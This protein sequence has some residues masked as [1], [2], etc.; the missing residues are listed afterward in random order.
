MSSNLLKIHKDSKDES[1]EN[2]DL[3]EIPASTIS[4]KW[5]NT[6]KTADDYTSENDLVGDVIIDQKKI[7]ISIESLT[8]DISAKIQNWG[9]EIDVADLENKFYS[10]MLSENS[11]VA[12]GSYQK[13]VFSIE[14]DNL[15]LKYYIIFKENSEFV[16]KHTH[17]FRRKGS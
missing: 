13:F 3:D 11:V 5:I 2:V 8:P 15:I 16:W 12:G 9:V 17:M 6:W 1:L 7:V 14:G 4:G 10:L